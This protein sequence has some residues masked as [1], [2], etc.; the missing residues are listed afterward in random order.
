VNREFKESSNQWTS[1][2]ATDPLWAVLSDPEKKGG[3]WNLEEFLAT[4]DADIERFSRLIERHSALRRPFGDVLDFGC[5]VGRLSLAWSKQ[6]RSVTGVDVASTMIDRAREV[7][8]GRPNATVRLNTE[9]NLAQ[10]STESFDV[11]ASHITLQHVPPEAA[12]MYIREFARITRPGGVTAFQIV[13]GRK[14]GDWKGHLADRLPWLATLH[15]RIALGFRVY[16]TSES[17]IRA[18]M[19]ELGMVLLSVE[20]D[21][22]AGE[23]ATSRT[24]L[25]AKPGTGP[26]K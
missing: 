16:V 8:S 6:A 13:T 25:F 3:K 23:V 2:G 1:L 7:L 20:T 5:G 15:H 12:L 19:Q 24:F 26:G 10:F 14:P 4:G 17:L 22:F 18:A 11:V 9:P 21:E